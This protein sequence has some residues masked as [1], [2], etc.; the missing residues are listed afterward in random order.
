MNRWNKTEIVLSN[1]VE[2][3]PDYDREMTIVVNWLPGYPAKTFG[4]PEDCYP[5]EGIQFEILEA[6]YDDGREVPDEIIEALGDD[7]ILDRLEVYSDYP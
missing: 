4:P 1:T 5:G 3:S 2:D 6:K 7:A